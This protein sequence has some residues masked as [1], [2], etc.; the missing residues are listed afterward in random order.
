MRFA[1]RPSRGRIWTPPF[2]TLP[3]LSQTVNPGYQTCALIKSLPTGGGDAL[4]AV[5]LSAVVSIEGSVTAAEQARLFKIARGFGLYNSGK[6]ISPVTVAYSELDE[7]PSSKKRVPRPVP[8][9]AYDESLNM[10]ELQK[11]ERLQKKIEA[12]KKQ[13]EQKQA[14]K[15]VAIRERNIT[16]QRQLKT[17]MAERKKA[18]RT[19]NANAAEAESSR[20]LVAAPLASRRRSTGDIGV[21]EPLTFA[22]SAEQHVVLQPQQQQLQQLQQIH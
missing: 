2:V 5:P 14:E 4:T 7:S 20:A 10:Q 9:D 13:A 1:V 17:E 16:L 11:G 18:D 8:T 22:S 15:L 21:V 6:I 19:A 12:A 3:G